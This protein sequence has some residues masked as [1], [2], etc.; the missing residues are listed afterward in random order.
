MSQSILHL[1]L[2]DIWIVSEAITN[3]MTVEIPVAAFCCRSTYAFLLGIY[4]GMKLS[5]HRTYVCL[6]SIITAKQ[7]SKIVTSVYAPTSSV[8]ESQFLFI[9]ANT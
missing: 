1:V 8:Q 3:A 7:F 2:I 6:A 4:P 5:V 9:L